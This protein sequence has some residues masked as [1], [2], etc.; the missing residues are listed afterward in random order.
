MPG[1]CPEECDSVEQQIQYFSSLR[2][3]DNCIG[4]QKQ[5]DD[6]AQQQRIQ[7]QLLERQ[8]REK[9]LSKHNYAFNDCDVFGDEKELWMYY[10]DTSNKACIDNAMLCMNANRKDSKNDNR[11]RITDE[12]F[13]RNPNNILRAITRYLCIMSFY[14]C[15][16]DWIFDVFYI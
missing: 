1:T 6:H 13:R 9:N 16:T 10:N 12:I 3:Y 2:M 11:D 4:L 7:Q 8:K 5:I 14:L 15:L